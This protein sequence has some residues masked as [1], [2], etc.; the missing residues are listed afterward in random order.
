MTRIK[1]Y[2]DSKKPGWFFSFSE[3]TAGPS[4]KPLGFE[5]Y[6]N[7]QSYGW[8][9]PDYG[10]DFDRFELYVDDGYQPDIQFVI[11]KS[12]YLTVGPAHFTPG[13]VFETHGETYV[14][15]QTNYYDVLAHNCDASRRIGY[16]DRFHLSSSLKIIKRARCLTTR[17]RLSDNRLSRTRTNQGWRIKSWLEYATHWLYQQSRDVVYDCYKVQALLE[18]HFFIDDVDDH[19][20]KPDYG[21]VVTKRDLRRVERLLFANRNRLLAKQGA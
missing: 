20:W 10:S 4:H 21:I 3:Y 1:L 12:Q 2:H 19:W 7:G 17:Y 6:K 11:S 15:D 13:T 9:R 14:V 5:V 18:Q 16:A 8:L